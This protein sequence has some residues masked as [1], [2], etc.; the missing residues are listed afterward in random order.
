VNPDNIVAEGEAILFDSHNNEHDLEY[1]AEKPWLGTSTVVKHPARDYAQRILARQPYAQPREQN[2]WGFIGNTLATAHLRPITPHRECRIQVDCGPFDRIGHADGITFRDE[3]DRPCPRDLAAYATVEE[4]KCFGSLDDADGVALAARQ[5][6]LY[7]AD[8]ERQIEQGNGHFPLAKFHDPAWDPWAMPIDR[9]PRGVKV[10][11]VVV[12]V[13]PRFGP[14]SITETNRPIKVVPL[15]MADKAQVRDFYDRKCKAIWRSG[16]AEQSDL[17][18]REWDHGA[19]GL[20]EFARRDIVSVADGPLAPD[21][22]RWAAEAIEVD[23]IRARRDRCQSELKSL[24]RRLGVRE[25]L[26]PNGTRIALVGDFGGPRE[27]WVKISPPR[28][29]IA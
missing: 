29:V 11:A 26:L 17:A 15:S 13:C 22:E 5:A 16:W 19:E 27:P 1:E 28:E 2:L 24:L 7:A 18:A 23:G 20:L 6:S 21:L 25:T 4:H 10:E 3:S 14:G 9:W 8:I 12:R